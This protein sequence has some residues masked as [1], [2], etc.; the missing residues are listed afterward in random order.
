MSFMTCCTEG[1]R[2]LPQKTKHTPQDISFLER[3]I[4]SQSF[5]FA[6]YRYLR[7]VPFL[8]FR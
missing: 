6:F 7:F 2:V 4:K 3:N 5:F 8:K 1:G